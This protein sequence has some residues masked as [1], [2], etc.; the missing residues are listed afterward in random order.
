MIAHGKGGFD[1]IFMDIQMPVMSGIKAT[2]AI[3]KAEGNAASPVPIIALSADTVAVQGAE[4]RTA[5]FTDAIT[6]PMRQRELLDMLASF[7]EN[8]G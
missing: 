7:G 6:K 4:Y 8:S 3:R 2:A 1:L 5:G